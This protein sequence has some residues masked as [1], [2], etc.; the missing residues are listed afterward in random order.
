MKKLEVKK[1]DLI[2]NL[3]SI[4]EILKDNTKIIAVVKA[5]GMG[6]GLVEY[7][8]FLVENNIECLAVANIEEAITL[9]NENLAVEILMLTPTYLKNELQLLIEN[10]ITIAIGSL[11][12]FE[13]AEEICH[14]INKEVKAHLKIDTGFGRYGFLY[15]EKEKILQVFRN[16][17]NVKIEG[18]FT[19]FSNPINEKYTNKQFERFEECISFIRE[20]G[21]EIDVL[22][23]CATT[24][25]IKYPYMQLDAVRIGSGIQGRVLLK[26]EKFKKVGTFK[27]VIQEIKELPKGYN[28]SY[29]N[30]YKTKRNTKIAIISVGYIDGL[31]R[32]KL[33]DDFSLKNN[34]I[35][36]VVELKK[37]FKN[38]LLKAEIN[39]V[40][41]KI[42][43]KLGMYH[44]VIDITGANEIKV[45]DEVILDITPIQT[46]DGIR[47][48]YI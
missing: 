28:I 18:M 44:A 12:E 45:G 5:N 35:S 33:R 48:E 15:T 40:K 19:H 25:T 42:I 16:C 41:Y 36:V 39:G 10:D 31:N 13:R 26:K 2:Y 34:L 22:H 17:E 29:N 4:R 32:N 14:E 47:R 21:F 27:T 9:K 1:E 30:T 43:G 6:L 8:K 46:N 38:N 7:S 3:N 20:N 37:I 24:A 23:A 11:E